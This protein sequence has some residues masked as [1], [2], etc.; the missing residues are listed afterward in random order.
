MEP[1]QNGRRDSASIEP[2]RP[3][4]SEG[5]T[6][7]P[8]AERSTRSTTIGE[9]RDTSPAEIATILRA[10]VG[11]PPDEAM[12][13]E[14]A[15]SLGRSLPAAVHAVDVEGWIA[16]CLVGLLVFGDERP[17]MRRAR[18]EAHRVLAVLAMIR[19][20]GNITHAAKGLGTSR[21]V[22]RER[23]KGAGLYPWPG[24]ETWGGGDDAA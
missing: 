18:T 13:G 23:L 1:V 14:L 11:L 16:W 2:L 15:A 10:V 17:A 19:T 3:E 22:L 4:I 7:L 24:S 6:V 21:R 20:G 5:S 8:H 12:P 9:R